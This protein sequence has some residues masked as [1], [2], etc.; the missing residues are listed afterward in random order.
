MLWRPCKLALNDGDPKAKVAEYAHARPHGGSQQADGEQA[1]HNEQAQDASEC[2]LTRAGYRD[3][4]IRIRC[5]LNEGCRQIWR[6][7]SAG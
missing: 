1:N 3:L 4:Q 7:W 2:H 6:K 5:C